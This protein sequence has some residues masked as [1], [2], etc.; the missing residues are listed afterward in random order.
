MSPRSYDRPLSVHPRPRG[1]HVGS[2]LPGVA[3]AGSSP[4]ARGT[5]GRA[6]VA[7]AGDRFIPARAGNTSPPTSPATAPPVHPRPRGEHDETAFHFGCRAG[8]SPPARGTLSG[9]R[10]P[11]AGHRFIP[12]R[13][14][15]TSSWR[16]RPTRS[17]VH[18]RPRGEHALLA[19]AVSPAYGSSP[20]ARGTRNKGGSVS[21]HNRFIPARA[22]NTRGC[23]LAHGLGSVHPRP[24]GEHPIAA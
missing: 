13:A 20:P 17:S 1:E 14:G 15:N 3:E 5:L 11:V 24:R 2:F 7:A 8:S 21:S 22:G 19:P 9:D 10:D 18:P 23:S 12:A 4:P 16:P 6:A